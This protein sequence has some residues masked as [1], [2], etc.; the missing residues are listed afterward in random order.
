MLRDRISQ[1][2]SASLRISASV[3]L[4]TV[5]SV[6]VESARADRRPL[7][8]D[9]HQRRVATGLRLR[10]FRTN[11]IG[12]PAVAGLSRVAAPAPTRPRP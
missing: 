6:S 8:R 3:D 2:S 1:P 5:L 7:W 12:A 9:R 4:E 10:L 11:G